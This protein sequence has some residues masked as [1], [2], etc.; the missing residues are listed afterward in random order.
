M[1]RKLLFAAITLLFAVW[2][3]GSKS[4]AQEAGTYYIQNVGTGK[5]LGP[6]NN[7]GTQA[8]VLPH[9]EFW[10]LA[11]ISDGIYSLESV[12]SNGGTSYYLNFA[13]GSF[14]CDQPKGEF[15][16]TLVN[17]NV[18]NIA[19][20]DGKYLV[21][22]G[23]IVEASGTDANANVAKWTLYTEA[24]MN[25][26]MVAATLDN[27]I[28]VTWRIKDHTFGRNNRYVSSW[29]NNGSATLTGGNSNKHSAE[30]WHGTFDVSQEVS[31]LPKG[32][33]MLT[34]QGFWSQ[35]GSDNENLPVIY[36]NN[37]T[38]LLPFKTGSENSM[39]QGCASFEDGLYTIEP[40]FVNLT[41]DGSIKVGAKLEVNTTLWCMWD[42]FELTYYGETT[43]NDVKIA[44]LKKEVVK[45]RAEVTDVKENTPMT[46]VAK[47]V[48]E[49]ALSA[50]AT[51]EYSIEAYNEAIN[52]L[53][54]ALSHIYVVSNIYIAEGR[55][56]DNSLYGWVCENDGVFHINTWSSEGNNDGSE[57]KTPFIEN[58]VYRTSKLNEGRV[59]LKLEGL[60]PGEVYYAEALVRSYN[61]ASADEPN[62][63]DFFIN[64]AVTDMAT[65]VDDDQNRLGKPFTYNGMSGI[66]ATLGGAATVDANGTLTLGVKIGSGANYNWV[67]FK[68]VTIRSMSDAL[69]AKISDAKE[70]A[71]SVEDE[72]ISE[73][74]KT[75]LAQAIEY[76]DDA[77]LLPANYLAAINQL[78]KAIQKVKPLHAAYIK[79]SAMKELVDANNFYTDEAYQE[80]YGQWLTK[81]N[82]GTLTEE[83]ANAL[84]NPNQKAYKNAALTVDNFLLSVWNTEPDYVEGAPYLINTWST[85]GESD[86]SNFATPFFEYWTGDGN[87]LEPRTLTG[88]IEGLDE[89]YYKVTAWVRVRANNNHKD[90]PMGISM[91]LNDAIEY[92][93]ANG[94]RIGTSQF[95]IH[96]VTV[97]GEVGSDGVLQVKFN[98]EEGNTISWLAFKNVFWEEAS[99]AEY[100]FYVIEQ[101]LKQVKVNIAADV[102]Y[103]TFIAPFE[104]KALPGGIKAYTVDEMGTDGQLKMTELTSVP[105]YTPVV[106][107]AAD[108]AD[109]MIRNNELGEDPGEPYT[110]GVLTGVLYEQYAPFG[111]YVL[112]NL[113]VEDDEEETKVAFY[114]VEDLIP[115]PANKAYLY[116]EGS[117]AKVIFFPG[118]DEEATAIASLDVLTSG[119]DG[120]YTANGVQVN[121]LQKGLNIVKKGGKSYKIFVK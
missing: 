120:I 65:A 90:N 24:E 85:E 39:A 86:G 106:L 61:E 94:D 43:I 83:E 7:W 109:V 99:E 62:G 98:V 71:E 67:A 113:P 40:I 112:Q 63:P 37:E 52:T 75:Q 102:K 11:K 21:P 5:W 115:V 25:A 10:K 19:D 121:A 54:S 45:L 49:N 3:G 38:S 15:K 101:E 77:N 108:G 57:M 107:E 30:K 68:N 36:A 2:S 12:V 14:F 55:I 92:D 42:N 111:S 47:N 59:Y 73:Q 46:D 6:G 53:N 44:Q 60:K 104:V 96:E 13:N 114:H 81:F 1:K 88:T 116:V 41:E 16:F 18:Y 48:L 4:F 118:E 74:F 79:L 95:Y 103:S 31:N 110:C 89:G 80:Y 58:W 64:D 29:T 56:P 91:Q 119:Y 69:A 33:Y 105:A 35:D 17:G 26:A 100:D 9:A 66:Y 117:A 76:A 32:V 34:A 82:E 72:D 27:P 93:A 51:I 84:Q 70:L 28:D 78:D 22:N 87:S 8:S 20:K 23:N 50:T 97:Y